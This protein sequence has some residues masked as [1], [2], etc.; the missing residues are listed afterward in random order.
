MGIFSTSA[1]KQL[2]WIVI[3]IA[4]IVIIWDFS[5]KL[6]GLILVAL[7]LLMIF[8]GVKNGTLAKGV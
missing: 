3:G 8:A 6:G 4:S 2:V 5:P 7:I 1:T